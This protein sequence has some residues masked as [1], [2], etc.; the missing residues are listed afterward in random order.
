MASPRDI[1]VWLRTIINVVAFIGVGATL[2]GWVQREVGIIILICA[3]I[4]FV[5]EILPWVRGQVKRRPS[6]SLVVLMVVGAVA[7]AAA[8]WMLRSNATPPQQVLEETKK[9]QRV[10]TDYQRTRLTAIFSKPEYQGQIVVILVSGDDSWIYA[11]EIASLF[12]K[13]KVL[14]PFN[15]D[16][17]ELAMD[18]QVSSSNLIPPPSQ[19]PRMV[20]SSFQFVQ[21]KGRAN[22]ILDP[23][24][25]PNVT[26]VWVGPQSPDG[27]TPDLHVPQSTHL[28]EILKANSVTLPLQVS[29]EKSASDVS[30]SPKEDKPPTLLDLFTKDLPNTVK[31]SDDG[32][33]ITWKNRTILHIKRQVYLD[34]DADTKFVGFYIPATDPMS[35]VETAEACLALDENNAV[36]ET[37]DNMSQRGLVIT[38]GYRDQMTKAQDLTFSG[39]VLIY[40]EAFL[41]I[42]QKADIMRAYASKHYDVQFR[43]PD[44]L[45]DQDAAWYRAHKEKLKR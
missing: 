35:S 14:G 18:V 2:I 29:H 1:P 42:P 24:V 39:R 41:S 8:W 45:G 33:G 12:D 21:L 36:Q 17:S 9:E 4:Y 30:V 32:F 27:V 28:Q 11:R 16:K 34:F 31:G 7:G 25:P 37:L 10:L 6:V 19:I 20:L 5:W 38:G 22:L 44:Y 40:H 13:W 3:P 15:A 43:G 23:D 26:V